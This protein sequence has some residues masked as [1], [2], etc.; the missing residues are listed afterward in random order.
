M[1]RDRGPDGPLTMIQHG[2]SLGSEG[3][4]ARKVPPGTPPWIHMPMDAHTPRHLDAAVGTAVLPQ[5]AWSSL[6]TGSPR[7]VSSVLAE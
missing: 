6:G 4:T 1:L 7:D 5:G 3:T 2:M